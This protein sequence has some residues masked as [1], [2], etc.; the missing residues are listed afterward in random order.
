MPPPL[1]LG[2]HKHPSIDCQSFLLIIGPH[3]IHPFDALG[4]NTRA[5]ER[6]PAFCSYFSLTYYQHLYDTVPVLVAGVM[7]TF[8]VEKSPLFQPPSAL[9]LSLL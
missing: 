1:P 2:D 3:L 9:S 4:P 5:H 8:P 7:I 6:L